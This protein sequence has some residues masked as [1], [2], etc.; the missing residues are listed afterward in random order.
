MADNPKPSSSSQDQPDDPQPAAQ[1]SADQGREPDEVASPQQAA[2]AAGTSVLSLLVKLFALPAS[3]CGLHALCPVGFPCMQDGCKQLV[4]HE[5]LHLSLF[6][7]VEGLSCSAA[8]VEHVS[9]LADCLF[10]ML[11]SETV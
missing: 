9:M 11:S 2:D 7:K 10:R 8:I 4:M 1:G 3:A 5:A 6:Q